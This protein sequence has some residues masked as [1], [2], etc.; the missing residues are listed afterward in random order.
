MIRRA[1]GA[2]L[3]LILIV[4]ATACTPKDDGRSTAEALA[5]ALSAHS[6]KKLSFNEPAAAVQKELTTMVDALDP[7][8]PTVTL[9]DVKAVDGDTA[10]A[11]LDYT[12]ALPK[13]RKTW[14]YT[15]TADMQRDGEGWDIQWRP[16]MIEPTLKSGDT[17]ALGTKTPTRGNILA[18]DGAAIVKNRPVKVVGLNKDGLSDAQAATSAAALAAAVDIDPGD[19]AAKVK[20]YGPKAFVEAITLRV[21][22]YKD[23]DAGELNSVVGFMAVDDTL[24]L[25]PTRTFASAILGSVREATAEDIK[26]SDGTVV[27]GETVGASGLEATFNGRLTGTPGLTISAVSPAVPAATAT[28][29]AGTDASAS[30]SDP[31]AS[32]GRA[33]ERTLFSLDPV[34]GKDVKTT[35]I[36]KLQKAG[37]A[38]LAR[39]SS[40]SSI[41]AIRPSTGAILAAANG[42]DSN[43]YNTAFLGR[44]A[45]GST[46]KIAT[47]LGLLR[48]GMTPKS[49]ITCSPSF[50]ADGKKFQ[51]AESYPASALGQIPLTVAIAH[52][53]NTAFVSE[54]QNLSQAKLAD[55]AG[56]LGIGMTEDLGLP[57]F[58]G[59]V[60]RDDTGTAHAASMIGQGRVQVSPL[61]LANMMASTVAG[62]AVVPQLVA[63][64]DENVK[65]PKVPK[66][67]AKEAKDLRTM[68]RAVVTEGYLTDL[69]DLPGK[70]VIG[71][72]GTA[73]YGT[74]S[75]PQTHSWVI[76]AQGDLAIAVF[77]EDGDLGA[78]TGGPLA[79]TFLQAAAGS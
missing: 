63:G 38:A 17:L 20:A 25:A 50:Y 57:D 16:A 19:Y 66:L 6:V 59:S 77:V 43:G 23:L 52:S 30:P 54:Y 28:A 55:A 56:A 10:R 71:K 11:S 27:A 49:Q 35:L 18:S 44:Y 15:A 51:N 67:T 72:T 76:A 1:L 40:P 5:K 46:F 12:W 78:I 79:K 14:T 64:H 9:A 70:K 31:A 4:S 68:M 29:S 62:K 61:A 75:P 3:A 21:P 53:C 73:E 65:L 37:E 13:T 26:K 8:W 69:L 47:S 36:P 32:D 74:E 41:V 48:Q 22:D 24:P 42:P 34:A 7:L 58:M 45:P 2:V 39:I 33:A 60:P